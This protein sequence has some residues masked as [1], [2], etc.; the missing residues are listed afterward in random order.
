MSE[1]KLREE[2]IECIELW[3]SASA[4]LS[5]H[6]LTVSRLYKLGSK[7][8]RFDFLLFN[9]EEAKALRDFLNENLGE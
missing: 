9:L 4:S 7:E 2:R 1:V 3:D 6:H 8:E 5:E